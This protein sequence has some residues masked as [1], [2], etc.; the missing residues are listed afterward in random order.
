MTKLTEEQRKR[1]LDDP[2]W[3]P[4]C[5]SGNISGDE[6]DYGNSG[7]WQDVFCLHC[8]AEWSDAYEL[9]D[10]I[11]KTSNDQLETPSDEQ[12]HHQ[13]QPAQDSA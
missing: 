4:V 2:D 12:S 8:G 13:T 7:V 1:Y 5:G 11:L 9:V 10:V 6:W 3:C